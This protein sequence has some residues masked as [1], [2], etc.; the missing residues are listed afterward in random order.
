MTNILITL[1]A[2]AAFLAI[3]AMCD[4]VRVMRYHQTQARSQKVPFAEY[5]I[6]YERET[7]CHLT[8]LFYQAD[9]E[10]EYER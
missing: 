3:R 9:M 2:I 1:T 10:R 4:A 5:V 7:K 8:A 6:E